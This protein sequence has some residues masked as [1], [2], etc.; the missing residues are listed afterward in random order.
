MDDDDVT[1]RQM[2]QLPAGCGVREADCAAADPT[3]AAKAG[4]ATGRAI[5]AAVKRAVW[6]RDRGR[7]SYVDHTSGRRYGSQHLLQ[8][9]HVVP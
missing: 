2:M 9:D 7:C 5:P 1:R 6:R 8:I 4:G 3:S